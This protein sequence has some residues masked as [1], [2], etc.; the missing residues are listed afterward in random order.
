M[1][2]DF[3]KDMFQ[4]VQQL[5][6]EKNVSEIEKIQGRSLKKVG[7]RKAMSAEQLSSSIKKA[8]QEDEACFVLQSV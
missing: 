8:M 2:I 4:K 7:I 1:L 5:R 3:S 6:K